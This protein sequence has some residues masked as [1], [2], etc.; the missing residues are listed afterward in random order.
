MRIKTIVQ[1]AVTDRSQPEVE[2]E[3]FKFR[4]LSQ[5]RHPINFYLD[6]RQI[7]KKDLNFCPV[8]CLDTLLL[9]FGTDTC[10]VTM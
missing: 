9:I 5:P 8:S 4:V 6:R 2:L 1:S 3:I 10:S 7:L